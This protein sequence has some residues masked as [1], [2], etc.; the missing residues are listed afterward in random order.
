MARASK[1]KPVAEVDPDTFVPACPFTGK[2]LK[3]IKHGETG[4]WRAEGPFY[5][6]RFFH[7]RR[8]LVWHL[9]QVNGSDPGFSARVE[10]SVREVEPPSSS[11]V[12]DLVEKDRLIQDAVDDYVSE[13]RKALSLSK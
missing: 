12:A 4:M 6:T 11:P 9:M 5:F 8:E 2:E 10:I 1:K 3:L 13:N 7:Y